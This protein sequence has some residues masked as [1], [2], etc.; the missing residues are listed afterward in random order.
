MLRERALQL[1]RRLSEISDEVLT[2]YLGPP[3][4]EVLTQYPGPPEEGQTYYLGPPDR[5]EDPPAVQEREFNPEEGYKE[6]DDPTVGFVG[7][8]NRFLELLFLLPDW[9]FFS[10]VDEFFF[11]PEGRDV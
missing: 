9:E 2:F 8:K 7:R 4:A 11:R 3:P 6:G 5:E 10:K 1:Q